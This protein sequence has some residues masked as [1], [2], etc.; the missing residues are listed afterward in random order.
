MWRSV[1]EGPEP[2]KQS[3]ANI[4]RC[5]GQERVMMCEEESFR[6]MTMVEVNRF[7]ASGGDQGATPVPIPSTEVKSS[8]ADD[9]AAVRQWK[10]M[11]P[12][13]NEEPA[14]ENTLQALFYLKATVLTFSN[15]LL[16]VVISAAS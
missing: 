10:A 8:K 6:V 9:T 11:L 7:R 16:D 13:I 1:V 4:R 5:T 2:I 15:I 14:H 3:E 12:V